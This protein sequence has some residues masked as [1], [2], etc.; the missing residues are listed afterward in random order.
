MTKDEIQQNLIFLMIRGSQAYGTNTPESDIDYGGICMPSED[1]L[2]GI[3]SFEQEETWVDE[4]GDKVDKSI[5]VFSKAVDLMA[6]NNPNMMDYL[7]CPD[8]CVEF[9]H[10][11]WKQIRDNRDLF[12]SRNTKMSFLKYGLAQL[13]R[14]K[15]HRE[16][17]LNPPKTPDRKVYE[18]PDEPIF[19]ATQYETIAKLSSEYVAPELRDQFYADM[20]YMLDTDGAFIVKKYV[21]IS[22]YKLAIEL[23]KVRQAQFLRM[24]TSIE[25]EFLSPKYR[26]MAKRELK[27]IADCKN[28]DRYQEWVEARNP[29]RKA[30]EDKCG[31]DAKHGMHLLR[32][33]R[34]AAE[35]ME[36]KGINVDRTNIDADELLDIR[37]GNQSYETVMVKAN[38]AEARA[39]AAFRTCTL[40]EKPDYVAITELK[41][42]LLRDWYKS[43][44]R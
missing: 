6:A 31:F 19:P 3:D 33:T 29:K 18:L 24:I 36:G 2:Y 42:K 13:S 38:E 9:E 11:I 23:F 22:N 17:L 8:R 27:Y 26:N 39:E 15:T 37:L 44:L 7:C 32:L 10:P 12:I 14:I 28:Y 16:Y 35:I 30:L 5:Y 34:M 21:D 40:R 25:G 4:N 41:R 43:I 1:V 20:A